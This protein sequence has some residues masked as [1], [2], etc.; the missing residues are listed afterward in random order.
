VWICETS[1][2]CVTN[3]YSQSENIWSNP[4]P[5]YGYSNFIIRVDLENNRYYGEISYVPMTYWMTATGYSNGFEDTF[6]LSAYEFTYYRTFTVR[7]RES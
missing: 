6:E 1:P 4:N 7:W 5:S 2:I 3:Q